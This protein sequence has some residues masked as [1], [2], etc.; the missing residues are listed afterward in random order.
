MLFQQVIGQH[1]IKQRLIQT[2][3]GN[4]IS[5]AQLFFGYPGAG[6]LPLALAYAQYVHCTNRQPEDS[7]GECPSCKKHEKM[8]HPDAHFA[9]PVILSKDVRVSTHVIPKWREA[10][11]N[12]PYLTLDNWL[13][14]L[15]AESK[16]PIIAAEESGEILRKLSLTTFEAEYKIMI[17]W[18]AERMNVQAANKLLKI[19]EEPPDK[20]LFLLVTEQEDHLL[21][22]IVSRTQLVRV[23]RLPD[24]ELAAAVQQKFELSAADA[25][26]IAFQADGN[27][28]AAR[29]LIQ[30]QEQAAQNLTLF[31][32]W[33][34][35]CLKYDVAKWMEFLEVFSKGSREEQ[36]QFLTYALELIRE[37]L[38]WGY[39]GEQLVR[40][41]GEE[42]AWL[43][44]F[45]PFVHVN[46]GQQLME[47]INQAMQHIDRNGS[48]KIIMLDLSFKIN[49]LLHI[50]NP[51]K[52]KA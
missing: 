2:V 42:K 17:I 44:K 48:S 39:A 3:A 18:L 29:K 36:K 46:N 10:V 34:R 13:D 33:M 5:H 49:E 30:E 38:M 22:T 21:R 1:D 24:A 9:Y 37:C 31:Q 26:K 8:V 41:A 32:S 40:V 6:A 35:S 23:H 4:R 16:Q 20:T 50:P 52:V 12:E 28:A 7:C 47:Q 27:F 11:L 15:D 43:P 25:E 14:V 19:L 51:A 45:A